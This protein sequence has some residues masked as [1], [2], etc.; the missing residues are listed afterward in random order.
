MISAVLTAFRNVLI[1][2]GGLAAMATTSVLLTTIVLVLAPAIIFAMVR[3]GRYIHRLS[4]AAQELS[5]A[6]DSYGLETIDNIR[7]VQ[8]FSQEGD[9]SAGLARRL[10]AA[11]A[12]ADRRNLAQGIMSG[13]AIWMIFGAAVILA[14]IGGTQVLSDRQSE[15]L[16]SAFF[17]YA[18]VV[19]SSGAALSDTWAQL[20]ERRRLG[21][22][23]LRT[24]GSAGGNTGARRAATRCRR[25]STAK[26]GSATFRSAIRPG[27]PSPVLDR[28]DWTV[29][30][31]SKT[32]RSSAP[33]GRGN[34][35]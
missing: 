23:H 1:L 34:R 10:E 2:V 27:R 35:P 7:T 15:G 13:A 29:P 4:N 8:A 5:V 3:G 30:A 22:A 14:W 31:G 25:R 17:L 16:V 11:A 19:A 9:A 26:S 33:R 20:T 18:V 24:A 6:A 12:V 21:G 28:F 32:R